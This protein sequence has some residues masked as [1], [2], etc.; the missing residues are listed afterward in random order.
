MPMV[1]SLG[2]S[3]LSDIYLS[4]MR[5]ACLDKL[6]LNLRFLSIGAGNC[7]LEVLLASMLSGLGIRNFTLECLD[8]N[9]AMLDR[10]KKLAEAKAVS[11]LL[12]FKEADINR[13]KGVETYDVI[14][15]AQCLHHFMELEAIFDRVYECLSE[16]GYFVVQDMIGRNGHL[17]W[18]ETL[19]I[20]HELWKELPDSHKYNHQ[21]KRHEHEFSDWDCSTSGF[22]GIRAQDI[23]PLLVDKFNFEMFAGWGG[24]IDIFVDRSFGHNFNLNCEWDCRFIDKVGELNNS[25]L[26]DASIKPTKMF[27]AMSKTKS[28]NPRYWQNRSPDSCIRWPLS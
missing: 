11:D 9:P 13:W 20:I 23:L 1:N 26:L 19:N 12:S 6:D 5:N 27:A 2:Y 16:D 8:I 24:I 21:L 28:D 14:V 3:F 4:Y 10:G 18:P 25:K 22:E 15:A 17:R 7:E